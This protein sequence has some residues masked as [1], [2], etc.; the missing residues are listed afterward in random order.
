MTGRL[1]RKTFREVVRR[2]MVNEDDAFADII[3]RECEVILRAYDGEQQQ[4]RHHHTMSH[5]HTM[6]AAW[7]HYYSTGSRHSDKVA[8]LAI[9]FHECGLGGCLSSLFYLHGH[10]IYLFIQHSI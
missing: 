10:I 8:R 7:D 6:W 9:V 5:I 3:D 1:T 4:Q 2:Q